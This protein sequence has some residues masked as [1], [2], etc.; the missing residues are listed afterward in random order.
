[1]TSL[2]KETIISNEQWLNDHIEDKH[3]PKKS[4]PFFLFTY[5]A[6]LSVM[7]SFVDNLFTLLSIKKILLKHLI[8]VHEARNGKIPRNRFV[9]YTERCIQNHLNSKTHLAAYS[10][11]RSRENLTKLDEGAN[12]TAIRH[13]LKTEIRTLT[14][15][16]RYFIFHAD[17]QS[18][19]SSRSSCSLCSS[20]WINT[21]SSKPFLLMR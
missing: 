6:C 14:I 17:R 5:E 21:K 2:R 11:L 10:R 4:L 8:W 19:C 13:E 20:Y 16:S 1:M 7:T 3:Y 9:F 12:K 18:S 15:L